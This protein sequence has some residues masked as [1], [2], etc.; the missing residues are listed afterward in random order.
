MCTCRSLFKWFIQLNA[1]PIPS[2]H[3]LSLINSRPGFAEVI[4]LRTKA[5]LLQGVCP[6]KQLESRSCN[7]VHLNRAAHKITLQPKCSNMQ[8]FFFYILE[9][10]L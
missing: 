2:T 8:T 10:K 6:A 9:F 5:F 7:L 4:A 1:L 3:V